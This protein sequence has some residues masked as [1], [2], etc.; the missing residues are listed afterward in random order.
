MADN[1]Q[2]LR[3]DKMYRFAARGADASSSLYLRVADDL[4]QEV[5]NAPGDGPML[6]PQERDLATRFKV[7]RSTIRQA[8][9]LLEQY[10]LVQRRRGHGTLL[11]RPA[12]EALAV[13][14]L[15]NKHLLLYQFSAGAIRNNSF[16]GRILAGMVS[17]A[18]ANRQSIEVKCCFYPGEVPGDLY[19]L[20]DPQTVAGVLT[21]GMYDDK[22]LK[23]FSNNN[24]PC[25]CVD[26]WPRDAHTDSVTVDVEAEAFQAA[27]HLAERGY[28]TIGFGAFGRRRPGESIMIW[29]PDVWRF[30]S[31]LRR[32]ASHYGLLMR[33]EWVQTVPYADQL[34]QKSMDR[35]FMLDRLPE[36][37]VCFDDDVAD[38]VL[39]ALRGMR[40]RCPE[41]IGLVSRG[42]QG[43]SKKLLT[44]TECPIEEVGKAAVELILERIYRRRTHAVR[45]AVASVLMQ[46]ASTR[47]VR[48][49]GAVG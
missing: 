3:E 19:T 45:V 27:A 23:F 39:E 7:S 49:D 17:T 14:G 30:L 44:A 28:R 6:L 26:Y 46:G 21:C 25:V 41:D 18:K 13:W 5:T 33:D 37:M 15:R 24:I 2:K 42:G 9:A 20:P 12:G 47:Q 11:T 43:S 38:R 8:L 35:F 29:D 31:H 48:Q 32:A 22:F 34:A 1:V 16:Y 4:I 10:E 40:L 36:A